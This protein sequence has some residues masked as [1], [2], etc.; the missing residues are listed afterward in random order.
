MLEHLPPEV[1]IV[2]VGP[3]DGLQNESA[4]VSTAEKISLIES[5]GR[6]GL[7]Q[8]EIT[9]FVSPKW[10]PQ[11]ADAAAVASAVNLPAAVVT[12]ALVPNLNGLQA[13]KAAGLK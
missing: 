9:A 12:S 13:A 2:E 11:M 1:K 6:S 5:L 3:R 8:I 4:I 7:R 10:I